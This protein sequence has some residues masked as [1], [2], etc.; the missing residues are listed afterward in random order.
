MAAGAWAASAIGAV[1]G[2]GVT[3]SANM[4]GATVAMGV[5]ILGNLAA[6]AVFGSSQSQAQAQL[7]TYEASA[8]QNA[9]GR[10][11]FQ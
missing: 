2:A 5:S 7:P 3:I 9:Q 4:I 1:V 8:F 10:K 11:L 6:N